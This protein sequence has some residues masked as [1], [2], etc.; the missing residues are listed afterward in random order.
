[1]TMLEALPLPILE[2][3]LTQVRY[4]VYNNMLYYLANADLA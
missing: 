4:L 1:M 3:V 2:T